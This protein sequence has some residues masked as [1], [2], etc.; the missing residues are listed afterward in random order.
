MK[1]ITFYFLMLLGITA[2]SQVEIVENFDDIANGAV[3][4]GW[5]KTGSFGASTGFVCGGSGKSAYVGLTQTG[6]SASLITPYYTAI[7]NGTDVTMSFSVNVFEQFSQFPP[8]QYNAP[9]V[10]WGTVVLEYT[11]DGTNWL[12]ATTISDSNFTYS[13]INSCVSVAPFSIGALPSG[14]D[15]QARIVVN[16]V[17]KNDFAVIFVVDNLSI[18]QVATT[19]PNCDVALLSPAAGSNTAE[20]DVTLTWQAATGLATGYTVSVG[21]VSGG[22]DIVNAQTTNTTS[23]NL[24]GLDYE[25]EYFV[26][27]VP[28]NGEGAATSGCTEQSFT[29]RVEP[30]AGSSCSSPIVISS[31]PFVAMDDTNNYEDN[32]DASPCNNTYLSGK[33]VFYKIT[34]TT[35]VSINIEL[36]GIEGNGASIHVVEGCIDTAS[37]CLAYVASFSG[38]SRNLTDVVLSAN[39]TYYVVLSSS[40]NTRTYSYTMVVTQN[41]CVS[42]T[43]LLTPVADCANGQFN[44]DVDV[45]YLGSAT[46]LTLVDNFGNSNN[47]ISATGVVTFGPYPSGSEVDF[48]LT[49]NQDTTCSYE[50]STYY[51]CPPSNDECVDAISL[52]V[53]TDDS[54][55]IF[56]SASNAGA[57]ES[58]TNANTCASA[59]NNTNDVWFS[60]VATSEVTILEYQDITAAIGVGGTIQAT[61][62]LEG[63]CG[64]LTSLGCYVTNYVTFT[65][66]TIGN[67][68]YIRN[69]TRLDGEYAQDYKICLRE[70]PEAPV[71]DECANAIE[72]F[73][74]PDE[75]CANKVSGTT[76]GA[77]LSSDNTCST[78]GYGDV[79]YVFNPTVSGIYEFSLDRISTTPTSSY[80]VYEGTCGALVAKTSG[81]STSNQIITLDSNLSY[82]VMVQT[83]QVGDGIDFNLCVTQLPDAVTNNDCSSP[84]VI[85]ESNSLGNNKISGNLENSY[86]SPEACNTSYKTIWYSFTPTYT[87]IYY[88]NF[89]RVSGSSYYAVYTGNCSNLNTITGL[90]SCYNS[91]EKTG[92]LVADTTYLISV[93]VSATSSAEFELFVYPDSSLSI[94]SESFESFKYYPNPVVNTLTVKAKKTISN[95][96]VFNIV[97]QEVQKVVPNDLDA[98]LDMNQ[99]NNGVYFVKVTIEG[100]QKSFKVMKR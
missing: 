11:T 40:A 66:L 15:F 35:D 28:F 100:V 52:T 69:N 92:E 38:T 63:T 87:G 42:P 20:K 9:A 4:S 48:T 56:T 6:T 68:Y 89:K 51:F 19:V 78:E 62:L 54:C 18:T 83:S 27:I 17:N 24:T 95:I 79:W 8:A 46:S 23:Y 53:N 82:Y 10:N 45:N 58:T 44:V 73:V 34:P 49:N 26:N 36:N 59:S 94:E 7:S 60:F 3:P 47:T 21:T 96:S 39:K 31:F 16:A 91:T 33:D 65:N 76:V 50:E 97:G 57:T 70:A 88:F 77:T 81:C 1:K 74:S 99:L 25:T 64:T 2:F 5:S 41:S 32:Y 30:L 72:F 29:T 75:T 84:V 12:T 67:T 43:M 80:A 85:S 13:G 71:N 55:A 93:H 37:E 90:T 14:S 22:T 86:P 98:T 61:E